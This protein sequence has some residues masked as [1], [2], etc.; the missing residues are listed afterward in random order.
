MEGLTIQ[1]VVLAV[2]EGD[3]RPRLAEI[4]PRM[5]KDIALPP[6]LSRRET[7]G[8]AVPPKGFGLT[9]TVI[10]RRVGTGRCRL[11]VTEPGSESLA[12]SALRVN[13]ICSAYSRAN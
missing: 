12:P 9:A 3:D 8:I 7:R 13:R 10:G 1:L 4:A 2:Q 11:Q 6:C 5:S